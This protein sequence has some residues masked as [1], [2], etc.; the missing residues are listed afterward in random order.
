MIEATAVNPA[1]IM[2]HRR[3]ESA[4]VALAPIGMLLPTTLFHDFR[5]LWLHCA[6]RGKLRTADDPTVKKDL[7]YLI[8]RLDGLSRILAQE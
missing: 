2:T 8:I 5:S 6:V 1:P 7:Y 3:L 4:M